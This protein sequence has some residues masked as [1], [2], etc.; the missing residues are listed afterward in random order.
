MNL[1]LLQLGDSALPI[2]GYSQ[3]WG[4]EAA[5]QRGLVTN[6]VDLEN[7]TRSWLHFS[8]AP[9]DGCL[10][11]VACRHAAGEDWETVTK[12]NRLLEIGIAPKTL[13]DASREM[14]G[15]LL[16]LSE[17]WLWSQ[18]VAWTLR[19]QSEEWHHAPVFGAVAC[20][21]GASA[22]QALAVFL[23]QAASGMIS[24]GV[25]AIPIGHTH[26]QQI[27]GRLHPDVDQLA[28]RFADSEL[29]LAGS[30]APAYEVL[31]Y[32]QS[33]LYSRLFRS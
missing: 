25:R 4:L 7:W 33:H 9:M 23:H 10:V 26:G 17:T 27:L 24:A 29:S 11:A 19:E 18:T 32:E 31:C 22:R 20:A 5:I 30:F 8:L 21:A 13:R 2:G 6:A 3:S 15:R 1:R 28:E 14:G 16:A 12:A